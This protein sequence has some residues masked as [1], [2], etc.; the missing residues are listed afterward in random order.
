[1]VEMHRFVAGSELVFSPRLSQAA[2][3][4]QLNLVVSLFIVPGCSRQP[5][6]ADFSWFQL[7]L[8]PRFESAVLIGCTVPGNLEQPRTKVGLREWVEPKFENS[9]TC[10][11]FLLTATD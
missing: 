9:Q 8:S 1:M 5:Q 6:T 11:I 10:L 7:V 3:G 2:S 4:G